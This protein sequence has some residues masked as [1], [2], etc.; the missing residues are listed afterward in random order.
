KLHYTRNAGRIRDLPEVSLA[1]IGVR[2]GEIWPVGDIEGFDTQ[3]ETSGVGDLH[4]FHKREIHLGKSRT[5]HNVSSRIARLSRGKTFD[6]EGSGIKVAGESLF[7]AG[8]S[9]VAQ[10]VGTKTL[11]IVHRSVAHDVHRQPGVE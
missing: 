8:E 9:G 6:P 2:R 5:A 10:R 3:F 11:V 1:H 7:R 4:V